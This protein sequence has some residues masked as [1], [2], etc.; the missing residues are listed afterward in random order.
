ML[1][2][3]RKF[4]RPIV[5]PARQLIA[6]QL[7]VTSLRSTDVFNVSYPKSGTTWVAF[8]LASLL[9]EKSLPEVP[10]IPLKINDEE[11][12]VIDIN[13]EY[14]ETMKSLRAYKHMPEPRIFSV[15]APYDP[16]LPKVIYLVRDPRDVMVSYY[17]YH[18]R[19]YPDFDMSIEQF[20]INNR[21]RPC[22][23]GVHVTG[24]LAQ[25]ERDRLLLVRYEDLRKDGYYWFR[26]ISEFCGLDVTEEELKRAM[27]NS[28]FENMR[29]QEERFG[30]SGATGDNS[31]PFMRKGKAGSWQDELDPEL[32]QIIEKRYSELMERLGYTKAL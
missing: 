8:F 30:F 2:N 19:I 12:Y 1:Q 26:K 10:E 11:K 15:H 7:F 3:I 23:W 5:K 32:V 28:S 25:A 18:R 17:Y 31:I 13:Y 27:E 24:W 14:F 16:N 21:M 22:D 4:V 9:H 29:R 6:E 20:I